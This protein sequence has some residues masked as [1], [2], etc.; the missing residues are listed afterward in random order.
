MRPY[1][2]EDHEVVIPCHT[3]KADLRAAEVETED[4]AEQSD[5]E[6]GPCFCNEVGGHCAQ[7]RQ[8][9]TS[10]KEPSYGWLVSGRPNWAATR[11]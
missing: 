6:F 11:G 9:R 3:A 1:T 2:G 7:L 8:R 4:D 5:G 10:S